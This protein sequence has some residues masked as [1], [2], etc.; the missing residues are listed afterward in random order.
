ML[1]NSLISQP[2]EPCEHR[3]R[4]DGVCIPVGTEIHDREAIR[5]ARLH[6]AMASASR[7][8]LKPFTL[9]LLFHVFPCRD[10]LYIPVGTETVIS[11]HEAG[12]CKQVAT[13]STSRSGLKPII[14]KAMACHLA[15][16]D[17]LYIPVGTE[18]EQTGTPC[19]RRSESRRP[20]HPG[21]D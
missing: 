7:S 8:G 21:R 16:R 4:R 5:R 20:L 17:G 6:V 1:A 14:V 18:T 3:R 11:S 13:A 15:G 10:G 19:Y 9:F 2:L 12:T